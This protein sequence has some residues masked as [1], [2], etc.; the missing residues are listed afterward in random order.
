MPWIKNLLGRFFAAQSL[1]PG[2]SRKTT[3]HFESFKSYRIGE[4][5]EKG[6]QFES[7]DHMLC[8]YMIT[9]R[10]SP[11]EDD[12]SCSMAREFLLANRICVDDSFFQKP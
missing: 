9:T 8:V 12:G 11:F 6:I 7:E 10:R 3:L 2:K 4:Y 1:Q 5:E